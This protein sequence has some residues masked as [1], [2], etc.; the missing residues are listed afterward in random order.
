MRLFPGAPPIVVRR[1]FPGFIAP[2]IVVRRLLPVEGHL[3]PGIIPAISFPLFIFS[4]LE[5]LNLKCI[6]GKF[7]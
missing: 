6:L 1:L 2:P 5:I 7:P 3:F 4:Y